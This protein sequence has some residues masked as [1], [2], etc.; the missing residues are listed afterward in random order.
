QEI[1]KHDHDESIVSFMSQ[2]KEP[3]EGMRQGSTV[4]PLSELEY[5]VSPLSSTVGTTGRW[6][7]CPNGHLYVM[8]NCG[9]A[10][11]DSNCPVCGALVGG[12]HQ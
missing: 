1:K 12:H 10:M 9:Q 6:Y 4:P 8:Y 2:F 11:E 7:S 3:P 5:I